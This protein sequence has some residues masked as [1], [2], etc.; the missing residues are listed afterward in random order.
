MLDLNS[1]IMLYIYTSAFC[2][3]D[4]SH[5]FQLCSVID[6]YSVFFSDNKVNANMYSQFYSNESIKLK[7]LIKYL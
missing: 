4:K 3:G 5:P 1:K 7:V 6:L 2:C